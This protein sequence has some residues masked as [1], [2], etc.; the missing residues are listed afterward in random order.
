MPKKLAIRLLNNSDATD[1]RRFTEFSNICYSDRAARG[2]DYL[3]ADQDGETTRRRIEGREVWVAELD[4]RIVASF[5]ISA[6]GNAAGSWWYRQPGV[7]DVNQL[8]VH[9]DSRNH[10]LFSLFSLMM[11]AAEE[12]AVELGVVAL[13]G[14]VPTKRKKLLKVYQ[15]RGYRIVDYKWK[16]HARYG[17]V[18]ISKTFKSPGPKSSVFRRTM[19]KLKYCRRCIQYR[20]LQRP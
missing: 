6:P 7:A 8:A 11:D 5:C 19:R 13:A 3:P 9:P 14:T 20:V 16:R 4:R 15:R 12:R 17:S 2:I 1:V 10:G 18:I